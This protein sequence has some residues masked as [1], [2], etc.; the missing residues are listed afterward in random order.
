MQGNPLKSQIRSWPRNGP[1]A[2]TDNGIVEETLNVQQEKQEIRLLAYQLWIERG[3]PV[4]TPEVDWF[5]AEEKLAAKT[6]ADSQTSTIL[7]AAK[8]V[9]SALGSAASLVNSTTGLIS[10]GKASE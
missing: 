4:G 10:G 1:T 3:C 2:G 6:R 9:G 7:N 8:V 5:E